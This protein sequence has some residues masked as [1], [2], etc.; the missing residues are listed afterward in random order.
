MTN[1]LMLIKISYVILEK[2]AMYS[3]SLKLHNMVVIYNF[4]IT[5]V[6]II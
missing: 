4:I 6:V 2:K 3:N 1:D 5:I